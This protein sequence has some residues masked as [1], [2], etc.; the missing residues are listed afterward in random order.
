[1]TPVTL[2]RIDPVKNMHRWYYLNIQP[3]LFGNHCLIREYGR[4]GCSGQFRMTSY[5]T[6]DEAKTAFMK[7]QG[8]KERKGY[9][10]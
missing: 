7:Q 8:V 2:Y 1:M 6:E 9:A 4:I 3:D 5:P 10:A